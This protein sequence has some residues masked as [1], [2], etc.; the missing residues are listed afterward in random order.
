MKAIMDRLSLLGIGAKVTPDMRLSLSPVPPPDLLDEVKAHRDEIVQNLIRAGQAEARIRAWLAHIRETDPEMIAEVLA[1]CANDP[2][3]L[4]YFMTRARE[5]PPRR[6]I[7]R[8][9]GVA[10]VEESGKSGRQV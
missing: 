10:I 2:E 3:A 4:A 5:V 6:E 1:Q 9:R 7:G 8:V